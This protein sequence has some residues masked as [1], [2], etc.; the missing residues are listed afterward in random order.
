MVGMVSRVLMSLV[1]ALAG[2]SV[3]TGATATADPTVVR[4]LTISGTGVG[5][6]PAFDPAV[7]RYGVTTTA[8]TGGTL[9]VRATTSDPHGTVLIQGRPSTGPVTVQ[10]LDEGDEVSVIFRDA[11]GTTAHS[12]VYLPARFPA[13]KVEAD[14]GTVAPGVVGLTLSEWNQ[15]D[16]HFETALDRNGVPVYVRRLD[17]NGMDLKRQPDGSLTVG[18]V[19]KTRGRT[20]HAL[21]VLDPRLES[22]RP[23]ET[24][25]LRDTD[26]HD[27]ILLPNGHVVLLSYEWDAARQLT[28]SVI[29][30]L[31][32]DGEIVF[33]WDSA[34]HI[35]IDAET[36]ANLSRQSTWRGDYAH[37]NSV[38]V[39]ADGH[40]LASFRHTSS[41]MKIARYDDGA[42][43]AGDVMWRL[44][45]RLSDFDF[46]DDPHFGPCAQHTAYEVEDGKILIFDNGSAGGAMFPDHELCVNPADPSGP[47]VQRPFSRVTKYAVDET[48]GTAQL[49]WDHQ[50]TMPDA[51]GSPTRLF[52]LFAA[53]AVQ[54]PNGNT[55]IGWAS[56]RRMLASEVAPSG[57]VVWEVRDAD[58]DIGA[59]FFSYRAQKF[60]LPDAIDPVI[61]VP[62]STPTYAE[63]E[64]ATDG[65]GNT[66]EASYDYTVVRAELRPDNIVKVPGKP[67]KGN[68]VYGGWKKQK[69]VVKLLPKKRTK[70]ARV[71][72]QN[73]STVPAAFQVRGDKRNRSFKVR[74]VV[75][76]DNVSKAVR[77]GTWRT[78]VL[79]PGERVVLKV[80]LTRTK[81]ATKGDKRRFVVRTT[82]LGGSATRDA[83]AIAARARR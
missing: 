18:R 59:R 52:A 51:L 8:G 44:G 9:A 56:E 34:D 10:G 30:E 57:Q 22:T 31:D 74:Y 81:H 35:D 16:D 48:A 1:L 79:E 49:A 23:L 3:L 46:P 72:I 11:R 60:D 54:L 62:I 38:Q 80:R 19:T 77:K 41:V 6:Y 12:L 67:W 68:D 32:A 39:L 7:E 4:S 2:L 78:P 27:S 63:G 70:V 75:K 61:T 36:T 24:R 83:V 15:N 14:R 69:A 37:I 45:G 25:G 76:G 29:Q 55:L 17:A 66:T 20:G 28:D 13:L 50:R 5:M 43:R 82:T 64:V 71:R 65:H 47:A 33:E 42:H 26:G 40:F 58:P 21:H 53:S 73:D